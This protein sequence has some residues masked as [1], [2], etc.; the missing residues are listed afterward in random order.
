MP[1]KDH[2]ESPPLDPA[3]HYLLMMGRLAKV[4]L[5]NWSRVSQALY[6]PE[7]YKPT[8]DEVW[9]AHGRTLLAEARRAGFQPAW[10]IGREASGLGARR[11]A[12]KFLREHRDPCP[13]SY[14]V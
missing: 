9:L 4:N 10:S 8:P 3:M 2:S 14:S 12:L 11:W 6:Y 7:Q 13:P 1:K 5:G